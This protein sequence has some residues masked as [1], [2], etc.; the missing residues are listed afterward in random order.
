VPRG[1]HWFLASR[2]GQP[3]DPETQLREARPSQKTCLPR[4]ANHLSRKED[5][6]ATNRLRLLF[7]ALAAAMLLALSSVAP[8]LAA[9][10]RVEAPKGTV[11]QG[12]VKPFVGTLQGH[13]TTRATALG[14]L[15]TA[16]R[17]KPF[18]LGLVWSDIFGGAWKGFFV[19]SIA[20]ITPPPTA[21]WAFKMGQT[22]SGDGVGLAQVTASSRVLIYYTTFDPDT[23]ATQPTLG[24]SASPSHVEPGGSVTFTVRSFND[25]G[26]G[27]VAAGAWVWVNGVGSHVDGSGHLTVRLSTGRYQVRA[28]MPGAIRSRTLRVSAS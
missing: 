4:D 27:S 24:L 18:E 20:G 10:L 13:T 17:T 11:F 8:A 1:S 14:A 19:K 12:S 21:Y 23:G 6:L 2:E 26:I 22:L 5:A 16:S 15:V 9:G 7:A 25:K 28:T 3:Y